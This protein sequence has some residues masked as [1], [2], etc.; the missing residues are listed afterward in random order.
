M[1]NRGFVYY[2]RNTGWLRGS[3]IYKK[4]IFFV[5]NFGFSNNKRKFIAQTFFCHLQQLKFKCIPKF[6]VIKGSGVNAQID[7][8]KFNKWHL[9]QEHLTAIKEQINRCV[10]YLLLTNVT[11]LNITPS[12]RPVHDE[13]LE[14]FYL[15]IISF[16]DI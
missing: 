2:C 8:L 6:V 9:S 11:V 4:E 7:N 1:V 16:C 15:I 10:L 5:L 3:V 13:M 12:S 14:G